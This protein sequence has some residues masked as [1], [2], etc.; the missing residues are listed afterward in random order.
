MAGVEDE[1]LVTGQ[2]AEDRVGGE[3]PDVGPEPG[4]GAAERFDRRD[5][6]R[7]GCRLLDGQRR[8]LAFGKHGR[9][10]EA[11]AVDDLLAGGGRVVRCRVHGKIDRGREVVTNAAKRPVADRDMPVDQT[12]DIRHD[13]V[14]R[15]EVQATT[16][17]HW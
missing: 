14:N 5:Q 3:R 13:G 15:V 17:G 2:R 6:V 7:V 9:S 4:D 16:L 1:P 11:T 10:K 8:R 12:V